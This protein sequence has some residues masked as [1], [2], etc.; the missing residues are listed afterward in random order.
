[1]SKR[2][3]PGSDDDSSEVGS[4]EPV[5]KQRLVEFEP[6][7]ISS[8]SA[9][10][11][12]DAKVLAV[13]HYK[14]SER[15]Q[16]KERQIAQLQKRVEQMESRQAQDDA[17]LCIINRFWNRVQYF[18]YFRIDLEFQNFDEDVRILLQRFD[19]ETALEG[20][21]EKEC[22]GTRN[23]L[24]N[25]SH[26]ENEEMEGKLKQRVEFS[27]RAITKLIQVFD[28]I[29]QR[30]EK[31]AELIASC[32]SATNEDEKKVCGM[33]AVNGCITKWNKELSDENS[34]LQ[35][36]VTKLQAEN[37]SLSSKVSALED[38]LALMETRTEEISNSLEEVKYELDKSLRRECRLD[39]RLSEFT[40]SIF[41]IPLQYVRKAQEIELNGLKAINC[42]IPA[43]TTGTTN[44]SKVKLEELQ[45]DLETQTELAASRLQELQEMHEKNKNLMG[46]LESLRL[47]VNHVPP[48]VVRDS[49]EYISLQT[50]FSVL[51]VEASQMRQ[52]LDAA[53]TQ[54][55]ALRAAHANQ[56]EVMES[57]ECQAREQMQDTMNRHEEELYQVRNEYEMLRLE[58]EQ[59]LS[60]N[61]Q[62]ELLGLAL[63]VIW[64]SGA[65]KRC[66]GAVMGS[67]K[68]N[69]IPQELMSSYLL[70]DLAF[71]VRASLL[72][73]QVQIF[74]GPTHLFALFFCL[75]FSGPLNKEIR[76]M[77][78]SAKA[79]IQQLKQEANRFKRKWKEAV[80]S[81]AKCNKE[82]DTERRYRE[83]CLL[84][85]V[86]D[87]SDSVA[88]P[89]PEKNSSSTTDILSDGTTIDALGAN[90]FNDADD[91]NSSH[92]SKIIQ[93]LKK[94]IL[95]LQSR[96]DSMNSLTSDQRERVEIL[97]RERLL[98][99][100]N[101]KL[102]TH[103]R[104][105]VKADRREKM[106]YY[107][108]EAQRKIRSL[109]E[110][111][112]RLR[113]EAHSAKQEEEGLMNDV[114]T[115]GQAF[116]EMQ[117][118]NTRLLQQLKEKDD[119]NLK[120]MAERIRANQ[121]QKKM[122]EER[123]RTEERLSSI[124]N[125]LEAQQLMI[126]RLEEKE[127]LL[128]QK[129]TH[130]EHQLRL[131]EQ[132]AEMHKRKAVECAQTSAD[133][134]AQLEKCSGQLNDA[135]QALITKTTQ[136]EA[137]IYK[138]RRLEEDKNL[139]RK[140][141]ERAKKIEKMGTMDEVLSEEIRELKDLLTC[142]SCKVRR[143]DA[144]LTK[145]FHVFCMECMKT[146]YETRRRKCPKCNAGFG[147]NDY[148]RMYFT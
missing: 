58:F 82:L 37:S 125:Q 42:T 64:L 61:E 134:K 128:T 86:D 90:E 146:R 3:S 62:S 133:Y 99:N 129:N 30:N 34:K 73:E 80:S 74:P 20:E 67:T 78:A 100:E 36:I 101:D 141:L 96:L 137:D 145:C 91:D 77:L 76:L 95:E 111:N 107:S 48:D 18:Q 140:K 45:Q 113:K 6:V 126:G 4:E 38:E 52:Q 144:V 29:T 56:I 53:R 39:Y 65:N 75:F 14:L 109:E 87:E 124:Q 43:N 119:A 26:W 7:R 66:Y 63:S 116:E 40:I 2:S 31:I 32:S 27:R 135:Q 79:E 118:Q 16:Y 88:S 84:I 41:V 9:T 81:L 24:A 1:M 46:E 10:S 127:K 110:L 131:M 115:T 147:A 143:K 112:E 94:K 25:L 51:Y 104:K 19:A 139:Y 108:E 148:R 68:Y 130:I 71:C 93:K 55:A 106:K 47:N 103:L 121:Y 22:E 132:V 98:K 70:C 54:I 114:E 136:Q 50:Q 23:F 11:E 57:E 15:F 28:H 102:Q 117:E 8:V 5:K 138:I 142:P 120:L 85:E 49:A 122:S 13:Q 33:L 123:E 17:M 89:D 92:S 59:N 105:L 21:I 97:S 72:C 12:I 60:A 83:R 69:R 35:K 44:I